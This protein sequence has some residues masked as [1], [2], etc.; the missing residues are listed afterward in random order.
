M[1]YALR[2]IDDV[3]VA[4]R[5]F[6]RVLRPGGRVL[7]LEITRPTGVFGR[8]ALRLYMRAFVPLVARLLARRSDTPRL[9][10]YYWDTIEACIV[11]AEVMAALQRAGFTDVQRR[12]ELGIFSE[13]TATVPSR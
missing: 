2:H 10:R 6:R 13:Y 12:V 4:F 9:F 3:Q 7:V 11:P 1:G 8:L 5:E